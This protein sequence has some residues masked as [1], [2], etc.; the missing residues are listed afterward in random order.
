MGEW[1][2]MARVIQ[3]ENDIATTHPH[4][5]KYFVNKED[6]YNYTYGS[7]K[8]VKVCCPY[9]GTEKRPAQP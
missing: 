1:L 7:G 2:V 5:V 3:G 4:L 8:Y 9:C 6:V